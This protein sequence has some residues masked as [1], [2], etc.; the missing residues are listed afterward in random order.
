MAFDTFLGRPYMTFLGI[1]PVSVGFVAASA[2]ATS[3]R[4]MADTTLVPDRAITTVSAT[5]GVAFAVPAGCTR[6]TISYK[7]SAGFFTYATIIPGPGYVSSSCGLDFTAFRR[8]PDG[9]M[10]VFPDPRQVLVHTWV[11]ITGNG[12]SD[13]ERAMERKQKIDLPSP[14]MAGETWT[15][16]LRAYAETGGGGFFLPLARATV[17]GVLYGIRV[18]GE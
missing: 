1:P 17:S 3:G 15:F 14:T 7:F 13:V 10:T 4:F 5:I 11:I 9:S 2:S 18:V 6:L 16:F 12:S 8:K